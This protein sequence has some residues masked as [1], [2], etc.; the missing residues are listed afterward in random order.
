MG[1]VLRLSGFL[2][3]PLEI[4]THLQKLSGIEGCQAIA[5]PR[6]DGV[7]C[8]AFVILSP[9]ARLDEA[10]AIAHCK[11]GLANY[12]VP[13]RVFTVDDF[14]KTPSPNGFKIQRAR[15]RDIALERLR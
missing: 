13:L 15:L 6:P 2:V 10:A 14:P 1:D 3:N 7:R 11:R 5:V 9:G 12:K 4:E 8:V